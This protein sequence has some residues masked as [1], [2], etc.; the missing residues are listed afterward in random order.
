M[1]YA[2]GIRH[3]TH[4][5][6]CVKKSNQMMNLCG[7]AESF[8]TT[9]VDIIALLRASFTI[10]S[11]SSSSFSSPFPVYWRGRRF[12]SAS[13]SALT[14]VIALGWH[15]V[16]ATK[17]LRVDALR[18]QHLLFD[19]STYILYVL[20]HSL[21]RYIS[22]LYWKQARIYTESMSAEQCGPYT[23]SQMCRPP[24]ETWSLLLKYE[25]KTMKYVLIGMY[26]MSS[27]NRKNLSKAIS[28]IISELWP[29]WDPRRPV[30]CLMKVQK[31]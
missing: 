1:E 25:N 12:S 21:Y 27:E 29:I 30:S 6:Q 7:K 26:I 11:H 31:K 19:I 9:F 17:I 18:N 10:N 4:G 28:K 16:L 20:Q 14:R 22:V 5:T 24:G 23:S 15:L 2:M 3:D 8:F 13:Q